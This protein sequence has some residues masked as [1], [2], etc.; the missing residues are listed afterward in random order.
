MEVKFLLEPTPAVLVRVAVKGDI[1]VIVF[2]GS[3]V[4]LIGLISAWVVPLKRK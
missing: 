2:T 1:G 4:K 3:D